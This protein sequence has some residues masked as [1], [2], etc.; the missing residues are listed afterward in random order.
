MTT[1][2]TMTMPGTPDLREIR[3]RNLDW[4]IDWGEDGYQAKWKK[5]NYGLL[6]AATEE[7]LEDKI[8]HACIGAIGPEAPD[9][10]SC[11]KTKFPRYWMRPVHEGYVAVPRGTNLIVA[12]SL[13]DL[14]TKLQRPG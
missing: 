6:K 5:G 3:V 14:G 4:Q 9:E 10:L 12:E 13:E 2:D 1:D 11:L 7:E 8:R